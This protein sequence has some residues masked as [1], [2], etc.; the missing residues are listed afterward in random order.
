MKPEKSSTRRKMLEGAND[1]AKLKEIIGEIAVNS[2][3]VKYADAGE[4]FTRRAAIARLANLDFRAST[5]AVFIKDYITF[6]IK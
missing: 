4:Y 2:D 6:L 5:P 3:G 1:R